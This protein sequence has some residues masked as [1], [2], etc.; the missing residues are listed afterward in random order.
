ME[1]VVA[2]ASFPLTEMPMKPTGLEQESLSNLRPE[3][4]AGQGDFSTG[5]A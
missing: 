5:E 1:E 3:D 4:F 2:D